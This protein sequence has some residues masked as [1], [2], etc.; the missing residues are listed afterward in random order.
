MR[1]ACLIHFMGLWKHDV[2]SSTIRHE[3]TFLC[4][5]QSGVPD[6]NKYTTA[7]M[8]CDMCKYSTNQNCRGCLAT[9]LSN[10]FITQ[11]IYIYLY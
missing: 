4:Q 2:I 5:L 3:H 7:F 1:E 6:V 10:P 8:Q 11:Y 9:A